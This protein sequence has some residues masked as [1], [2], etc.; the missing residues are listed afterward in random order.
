M[1]QLEIEQNEQ[2][3]FDRFLDMHMYMTADRCERHWSTNGFN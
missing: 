2:C 1:S 3:G